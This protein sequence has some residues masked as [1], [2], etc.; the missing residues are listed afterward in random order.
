[1][2]VGFRAKEKQETCGYLNAQS[3]PAPPQKQVA[4]MSN[5]L[6]GLEKFSPKR[7]FAN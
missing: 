1:L 5:S 2:F 7:E 6:F 3:K 4:H